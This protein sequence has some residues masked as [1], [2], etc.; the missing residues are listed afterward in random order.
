[1]R[2]EAPLLSPGGAE[3]RPDRV[4]LHPDGR[5]DIIDYKFGQDQKKYRYQV[6]EYVNLYRKMG[7]EKVSGYLWYLEDNLIIFVD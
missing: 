5:A 2:C 4:V 6:R 3:H 1:M 7:Y